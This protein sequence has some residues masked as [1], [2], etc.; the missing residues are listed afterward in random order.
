M[1]T[2]SVAEKLSIKPGTTVWVLPASRAELIEP[3]PDGARAVKAIDEAAV[4]VIFAEDA[5]QLRARL[6]ERAESLA[7]PDSLWIAYPKANRT[8]INRDK[9]PPILGEHNMRPIGQVAVDETWSALRFRPLREGE[10]PFAGG[11]RR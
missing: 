5:A 8:D 1:S 9:L 3:L 2:K 7:E 10:A 6:D 11:R 4:A